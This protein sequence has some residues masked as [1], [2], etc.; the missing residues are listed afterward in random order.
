MD[1]RS[2]QIVTI[3]EC[4]DHCFAF[5]M[6]CEDFAPYLDPEEMIWGLDRAADLLSDASRLQSFLAL[7]K[8]DDFFGGVKPKPGDLTAADFGI[9][10]PSLLGE[11]GKTFLSEDERGRINKGVAHLTEHLSLADD[12][13]VELFEILKRSMPV[14]TRLV[15]GLRKL[16]TSEDAATWLDRTNDLIERGMKIKT[17]AEKLAEQAQARSG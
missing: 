9:E 6:W 10:T 2:A 5:A 8:L 7:R 15:A 1:K 17:P 11:A 12:S 13:E 14:F 16:D 3:C 4:I